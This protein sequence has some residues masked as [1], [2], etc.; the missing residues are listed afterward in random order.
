MYNI[1]TYDG[2][3]FTD[4]SLNSRYNFCE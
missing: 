4:H 1:Q 3:E 2:G